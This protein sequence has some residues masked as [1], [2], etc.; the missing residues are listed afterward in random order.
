MGAVI[1]KVRQ[2][3]GDPALR[4]YLLDRALGRQAPPPAF[5]AGRPPYLESTD[6][7]LPAGYP[8]FDELP[9]STPS[10]PLTIQLPGAML[11]LDPR[12]PGALFD[13]NFS[14]IETRLA[15]HRFAWLPLQAEGL[16]P[17]WPVVLWREW[18][19]RFGTPGS[20]WEWHPYTAAERLINLLD[21]ARRAGG[22]PGPAADTAGVL[23]AHGPAIAARLE[24]F[25]DHYTGNHLANNGRGLFILGCAMNW[26]QCAT[27]GGRIMLEEAR[28]IF[29]PSGLLRE[30]SSHYHLL[31]TRNYLSAWLTGRRA[32]RPETAELGAVAA[33]AWMAAKLFDLPGGLPLIGDISPDCPPSFLAGLASGEGD[34]WLALLPTEDRQALAGLKRD[35]G[36]AEPVGDG[37]AGARYGQWALLVHAA[38]Q[39]W[40][41]MPGHGHQDLGGFELHWR[42]L[43]LIVDPGRG[44]YGETGEAARYRAAEVHNGLTV[45]GA[46]PTPPNR[47]YYDDAFRL[48]EGGAPPVLQA[49]DGGVILVHSAFRRQGVRGCERQ[50]TLSDQGTIIK[51]RVDGRGTHDLT[52]TLVTTWPVRLQDG[53]AIIET[54]GGA[55]RVTADGRFSLSPLT[56]WRAY[57]RGEAA[58][59]ITIAERTALPWHGKII[60]EAI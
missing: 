48:R 30:G 6:I 23:A 57:G 13:H 41:F 31:L 15:V 44:T 9:L 37:W 8:K 45:D 42:G 34:G 29:T 17:A 4:R 52:R 46:D 32:G 27:L 58:T 14:D 50:W 1:R 39:G 18:R 40:P 56:R 26:D 12:T 36:A 5:T 33:S 43:P 59:R 53:A 35:I 10:T 38:P 11:T 25:G 54:P 49:D 51:D 22:L 19:A 7:P 3:L 20:G 21:F 28:R 55:V 16:D 2:V 24:Y 60:L 47:P